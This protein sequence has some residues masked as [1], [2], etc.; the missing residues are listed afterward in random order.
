[1]VKQIAAACRTQIYIQRIFLL[2]PLRINSNGDLSTG[3]HQIVYTYC[4][5]L[6]FVGCTFLIIFSTNKSSVFYTGNG[7]V[8]LISAFCDFVLGK[9]AFVAIVI[10]FER[11]K[12]LQISFFQSLARLDR[13]LKEEFNVTTNYGIYRR[14]NLMAT[15]CII[16]YYCTFTFVIG[17]PMVRVGI[18]SKYEILTIL[19]TFFAE[20]CVFAMV[21]TIFINGVMLIG[22][23][24]SSIKN[25]ILSKQVQDVEKLK[26]LWDV[27]TEM[28]I[29]INIWN[30]YIG[31]IVLIRLTHDFAVSTTTS[32]LLFSTIVDN[33]SKQSLLFNMPAF[34]VQ[35]L[36]RIVL[37]IVFAEQAIAKVSAKIIFFSY[38][39]KVKVA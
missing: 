33:N 36:M 27:Y 3:W 13:I 5:L 19:L 6:I 34:F 16:V 21:V 2:S 28:L 35:T 31:W 10:L 9:I 17:E 14:I 1:M 39:V 8:W 12:H 38:Y 20:L 26:K 15:F 11:K 24:F 32:Y 25:V 29:V 4:G 30:D 18:Y 7:L 37:F 22:N 23:K